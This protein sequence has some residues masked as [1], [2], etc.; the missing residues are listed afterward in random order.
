MAARRKEG[1]L[2]SP[3]S[4]RGATARMPEEKSSRLADFIL[5]GVR[6]PP[7]CLMIVASPLP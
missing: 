7:S 6:R 3:S 1:S 4:S 5:P 2:R